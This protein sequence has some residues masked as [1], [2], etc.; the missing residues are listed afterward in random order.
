MYD[1]VIG[2]KS[3]LNHYIKTLP[4]ILSDFAPKLD[5]L[6]NYFFPDILE[7]YISNPL[8]LVYPLSQKQVI[9]NFL[10]FFDVFIS[11]Y[12]NSKYRDWSFI[13]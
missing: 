7:K 1:N 8:N 2:N 13:A 6:I 5:R 4:V 9:T 12:K 3:L 11:D 10:T